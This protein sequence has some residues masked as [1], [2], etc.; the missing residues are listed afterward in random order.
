MLAFDV[1][2]QEEKTQ[3]NPTKQANK[4]NLPLPLS[5]NIRFAWKKGL[6]DIYYLIAKLLLVHAD[7]ILY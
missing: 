1:S 4:Q 2:H 3:Q 7:L 6:F 5:L